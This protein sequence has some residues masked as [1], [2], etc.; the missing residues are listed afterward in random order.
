MNSKF[1]F[2]F[3]ILVLITSSLNLLAAC[4]STSQG[5]NTISSQT[6]S[7]AQQIGTK[8]ELIPIHSDNVIAAGYDELSMVMAVQFSNGA[9]YEYYGVPTNLW[10]SFLAA[11]PH[12]W[13]QVGYPEL[14]RGGIPYKRIR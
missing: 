10:S 11:Q 6:I 14:V 1:K 4:S 9:L 2:K 12:P 3:A 7:S 8:G 13:S 5:S